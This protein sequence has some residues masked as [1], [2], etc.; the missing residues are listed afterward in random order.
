MHRWVPESGSESAAGLHVHSERFAICEKSGVAE[1]KGER[2]IN[3]TVR[4]E[5]HS[6]NIL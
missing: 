4:Q 1:T 3:L 5:I 2:V 6:V